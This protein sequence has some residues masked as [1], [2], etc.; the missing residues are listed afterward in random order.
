V[1]TALSIAGSDPTGGAGL[2]ADLKTFAAFGIH[3]LSAVTALTAQSTHSISTIH[4]VPT[5]FFADQLETLLSDIKPGALKTGMLHNA[6]IIDQLILSIKKHELVNLVVDPVSVSSSGTELIDNEGFKMLRD[7]LIPMA[8]VITPNLMEAERLTGLRISGESELIDAAKRLKQMG[9]ESVVITGGHW[10][11][12]ETVD[13]FLD[14]SEYDFFR[15]EKIKGEFHG[16]GCAFS[17]AITAGLAIGQRL[18]KAVHD[19]HLYVLGAITSA[20]RPG[21]GA[22]I[23]GSGGF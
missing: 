7:R 9:P 12:S 1:K 15:G 21:S 11:K 3:G 14:G 19:A 2:Q 6:G 22:S 23:L 17:A 18:K 8:R 4:P 5:D 10:R 13:F 16:T 20:F